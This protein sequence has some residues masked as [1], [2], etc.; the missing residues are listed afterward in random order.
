M[1]EAERSQK[2]PLPFPTTLSKSILSIFNK[3]SAK[4]VFDYKKINIVV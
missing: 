4:D 2:S 3:P 1:E